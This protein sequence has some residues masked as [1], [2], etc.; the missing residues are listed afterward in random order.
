[1]VI[2]TDEAPFNGFQTMFNAFY[3]MFDAFHAMFEASNTTRQLIQAYIESRL[4][5]T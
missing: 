5:G 1:V 2:D 4:S 3:A